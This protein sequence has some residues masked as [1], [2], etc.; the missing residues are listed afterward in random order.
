MS[1]SD[2]RL[3]LRRKELLRGRCR[4]AGR[5]G[6]AGLSAAGS[7]MAVRGAG[8]GR[9]GR[10]RSRVPYTSSAEPRNSG[11]AGGFR[12]SG[13]LHEGRGSGAHLTENKVGY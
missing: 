8:V 12:G 5:S 6:I 9:G 1:E 2:S 11:L 10:F 13:G 4:V 3:R 7:G